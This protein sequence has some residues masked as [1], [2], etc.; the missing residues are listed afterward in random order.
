MERK[1]LKTLPLFFCCLLIGCVTYPRL[2]WKTEKGQATIGN[3]KAI[4]IKGQIIKE[5]DTLSRITETV[6]D[7]KTVS[8]DDKGRYDFTLR[9]FVWEF[10]NLLTRS[11]CTS[12][13]QLYTCKKECK[14]VDSVD[15]DI[16]GE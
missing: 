6:E 3:G 4:Q 11:R 13:V 5:C 8:T 1:I 9:A 7:E 10:R 14:P 12:H 15:I 2:Y 16:L